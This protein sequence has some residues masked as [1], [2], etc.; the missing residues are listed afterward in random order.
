[1]D[2]HLYAIVEELPPAW[3]PPSAPSG[4]SVALTR[5][6]GLT[7]VTSPVERTPAASAPALAR[8]DTI[9]ASLLHV[10]AVL[11]FRFGLVV[12]TADLPGWIAAHAPSLRA[13]LGQ[14]RGCV[15][16]D[17][18]LLRLHCAHAVGLVCPACA[19]GTPDADGLRAVGDR[20][21]EQA[22]VARW[23]YRSA[24]GAQGNAAASVAFLVPRREV[25]AFLSRIAPVASRAQGIA[26]VPTGPW[27]PYSF[28]PPVDRLPLAPAAGLG[29][30]RTAGGGAPAPRPR[31]A[32]G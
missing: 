19:G 13:S 4:P 32:D 26:V 7:A 14:V 31:A 5:V 12:A 20:L 9:V 2:S 28:A 29:G 15:E 8:H 27:P 6:A 10:G 18:R 17:V 25:A 3:R 1:M 22:G 24:A 23:R 30:V 16:M 21:I 11:P